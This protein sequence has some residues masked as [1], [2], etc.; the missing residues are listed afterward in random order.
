M[1]NIEPK[2]NHLHISNRKNEIRG[3]EKKKREGERESER[4]RERERES[5]REGKRVREGKQS[6]ETIIKIM[7]IRKQR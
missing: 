3:N 5:K 4:E 6:I 7:T 2:R 1:I